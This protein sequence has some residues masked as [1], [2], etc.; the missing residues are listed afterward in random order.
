MF[1]KW[2]PWWLCFLTGPQCPSWF[3]CLIVA[4]VLPAFE[5]G[6]HHTGVR[7]ARFQPWLLPT[8]REEPGGYLA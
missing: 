5:G 4:L 2:Y 3:C 7:W 1:P 8:W 6:R